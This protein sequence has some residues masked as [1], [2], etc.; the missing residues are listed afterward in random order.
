MA[1]TNPRS[2][3]PLGPLLVSL[4]LPLAGFTH[5]LT[6]SSKFFSPFP[7][8]T[9]LL[10]VSGLYLALCGVYHTLRAAVPSNPTLCCRAVQQT[11]NC[12]LRACHPLWDLATV[13]WDLGTS[14]WSLALQLNTT[15]RSASPQSDL[16]LGSSLFVRHY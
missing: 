16:A 6:L 2:L 9:C 5:S 3:N 8:G 13:R 10:S 1:R 7:H 14:D 4:C 12:P 11:Y 15:S